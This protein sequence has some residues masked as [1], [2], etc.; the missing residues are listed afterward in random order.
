MSAIIYFFI[1]KE[2]PWINIKI[3]NGTQFH[4]RTLNVKYF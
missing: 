2:A 3:N 1:V 4:N